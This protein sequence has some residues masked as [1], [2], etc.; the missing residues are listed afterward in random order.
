VQPLSTVFQDELEA[1]LAAKG[2]N[3][4]D[5][6]QRAAS[7]RAT[8]LKWRRR[9]PS[10]NAP[11]AD[12]APSLADQIEPAEV[13]RAINAFMPTNVPIPSTSVANT[14]ASTGVPAWA[15]SS[16]AATSASKIKQNTFDGVTATTYGKWPTTMA[17]REDTAPSYGARPGYGTATLKAMHTLAEKRG[18]DMSRASDRDRAAALL[19][20]EG[21]VPLSR[22]GSF[23]QGLHAILRDRLGVRPELIQ[24][25]ENM[26]KIA[27][28]T[29]ILARERP[30]LVDSYTSPAPQAEDVRAVAFSDAVDTELGSLDVLDPNRLSEA[31]R[32]AAARYGRLVPNDYGSVPRRV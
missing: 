3:R 29:R 8:L 31:T 23:E 14:T 7:A 25:A 21:G 13:A 26:G 1:D 17:E 27:E 32:R 6:T 9:P 16:D 4:D 12:T 10:P 19:F 15:R 28:A 24:F 30:D 5:S 20:A 18:L 22:A 2:G 11:G